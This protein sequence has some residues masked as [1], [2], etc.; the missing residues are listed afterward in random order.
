[1]LLPNTP[2]ASLLNVI[3]AFPSLRTN[4]DLFVSCA[5][6]F[7][8]RRLGISDQQQNAAAQQQ[9]PD[10][11]VGWGRLEVTHHAQHASHPGEARRPRPDAGEPGRA[12]ERELLRRL[13]GQRLLNPQ[14]V[15]CAATAERAL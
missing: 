14:D 4:I 5:G 9:L 6:A 15:L 3:D 10:A 12:G 7:V 13:P 2:P 11:P 8:S 1:M